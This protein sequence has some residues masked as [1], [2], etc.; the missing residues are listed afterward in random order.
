MTYITLSIL[1]TNLFFKKRFENTELLKYL[2]WFIEMQDNCML[3]DNWTTV[4]M[5]QQ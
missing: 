4:K 1:R 2:N 5:Y 3:R